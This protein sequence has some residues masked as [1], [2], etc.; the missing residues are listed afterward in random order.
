MRIHFTSIQIILS[1]S[2]LCCHVLSSPTLHLVTLPIIHNTLF[3]STSLYLPSNNFP[4]ATKPPLTSLPTSCQTMS[5]VKQSHQTTWHYYAAPML[6]LTCH[7]FLSLFRTTKPPKPP[8]YATNLPAT[9]PPLCYQPTSHIST[10]VSTHQ[11]H[12]HLCMCYQPISNIS[13]SLTTHQQHFHLCATN[14]HS[15]PGHPKA[16]W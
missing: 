14:P 7:I 2:L 1:Y 15:Q 16:L 6:P 11:Q 8:P 3:C 4:L 10:S 9:S 13:T 12:L 5:S